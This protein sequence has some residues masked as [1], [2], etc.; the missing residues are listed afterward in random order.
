MI[1]VYTARRIHTM[2]PSLP[3]AT[4]IAVREGRIVE[5][6]TLD[7]L[8]PWLDVHEHE[9]VDCFTDAVVLPGLIDPHVHPAMM[10]M[11]MATEWVTPEA[12]ELPGRQVPAVIG[13]DA[14]LA[15]LVKLE[16]AHPPQEPFITFGWHR[17]FHGEIVRSDLEAISD[18]RPVVVWGR[19][20][21]ELRC[22]GPALE[23]IEAAEGAAWDPH[24]DLEQGRLWES[25]MS[26]ALQRLREVLMS[27]G[28]FEAKMKEVGQLVHLGGVTTIA[29]AGFGGMALPERELEVLSQVH[30]GDQVPFRQYLI[31]QVGT[32][33]RLY[34][35][36]AFERMAALP[37][38]SS[39]RI[40]F[41]DAGKFFADGA[42]I[43]QLMQLGEPGYID[44][45]EG[46]WMAEPDRIVQHLRPFWTAG[47]QVNVHVNGDRG[48]DA[49]LDA[50]AQL[51]DEKP[52][53][54]HRTVL[55]HFGV[56]T[57]AQSR[58]G[59][60]LGCAVQAN[61][62]YLRFFGDQYV[63]EGL[64]TERASQM[65]RL[66]SARRN[67]MSVALH[68]DLPMGPLRPLLAASIAATRL[69]GS[70]VVLGEYE[71]L[72]PYDAIAAVTIEAAWQ[73]F[74]DGEIGSLA[75]GKLADLTV[76]EADPFEMDP[77]GWPD[78]EIRC[79]MLSGKLY[80]LSP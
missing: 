75:A 59:A 64:G 27:N 67:G 68:S 18:T 43:A 3:E 71:C 5:V 15:Q 17:Q 19:S 44:G 74:L 63:A 20:F 78:I 76:L 70:G 58:R 41:L 56:T 1:T 62:Y 46:A 6:G 52:R 12:W 37:N 36:E 69:S 73:L 35:D 42:F 30:E 26:W 31:P 22:N 21:H 29:D 80:P 32:F 50:I 2:D 11:L 77:K 54:D 61:G 34:G 66:G 48:M 53:F 13:R 8:R 49:T 40:R 51:Q 23:M 45:H 60:A 25:G 33:K 72:S 10:A 16:A 4:A 38:Q 9:V 24:I 79:T 57:Q 14:Y 39:E 47:K 28:Q 7:S 55:H 65:T